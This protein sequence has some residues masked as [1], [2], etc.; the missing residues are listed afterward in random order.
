MGSSGWGDFVRGFWYFATGH[1]DVGGVCSWL[2][3]GFCGYFC[4]GDPGG[5]VV[6]W[7]TAGVGRVGGVAVARADAIF[8]CKNAAV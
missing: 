6:A 1:A 5:W 8:A 3:D 2:G 4:G 7:G